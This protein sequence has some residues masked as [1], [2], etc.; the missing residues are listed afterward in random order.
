MRGP[1]EA[2]WKQ[3]DFANPAATIIE[4]S[5]SC[6]GSVS[7]QACPDILQASLAFIMSP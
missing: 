2:C 5:L 1:A 6:D 4:T 3:F 7:A